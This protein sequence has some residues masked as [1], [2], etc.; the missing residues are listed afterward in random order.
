MS[1]PLWNGT[2][3]VRPALPNLH[4]A[5]PLKKRDHLARLENWDRAHAYA[6]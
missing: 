2:V 6:T 1:R 3:V 5:E 4:K